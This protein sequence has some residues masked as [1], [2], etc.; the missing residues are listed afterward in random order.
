MMGILY[1]IYKNPG[2]A[3]DPSRMAENEPEERNS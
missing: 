3:A 2:I 1:D